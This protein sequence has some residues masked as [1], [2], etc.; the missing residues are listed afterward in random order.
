MS[1]FYSL[2]TLPRRSSL[3]AFFAGLLVGIMLAP[4]VVRCG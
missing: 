1:V 3:Y 4:L 2:L